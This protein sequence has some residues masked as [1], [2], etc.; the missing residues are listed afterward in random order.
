MPIAAISRGFGQVDCEENER[1]RRKDEFSESLGPFP[2]RYFNLFSTLSREK[3]KREV[4]HTELV[5]YLPTGALSLVHHS[6]FPFDIY[7]WTTLTWDMSLLFWTLL[8]LYP[9]SVKRWKHW[10]AQTSVAHTVNPLVWYRHFQGILSAL[11]ITKSAGW[12]HPSRPHRKIK[13]YFYFAKVS[14]KG[15]P[16]SLFSLLLK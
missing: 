15:K 9:P 2:L 7:R 4:S 13:I 5:G 12:H 11:S 10:A 14:T 3:K 1:E 6:L 8:A 16:F